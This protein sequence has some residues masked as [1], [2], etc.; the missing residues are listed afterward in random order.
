[1]MLLNCRKDNLIV[2][3]NVDQSSIPASTMI[4]FLALSARWRIPFIDKSTSGLE[5]II[6]QSTS[7]SSSSSSSLRVRHCVQSFVSRIQKRQCHF[8]FLSRT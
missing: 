7:P 5:K 2:S 4:S 1:M 3:K 8:F 6:L